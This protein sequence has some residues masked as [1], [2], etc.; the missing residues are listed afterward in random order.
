MRSFICF[1]VMGAVWVATAKSF[2][3]SQASS[4]AECKRL[5]SEAQTQIE[6]IES[7]IEKNTMSLQQIRIDL[8]SLR[9]LLQKE[10]E[11]SSSSKLL[12][13]PG[14]VVSPLEHSNKR[15]SPSEM[16]DRL[17]RTHQSVRTPDKPTQPSGI[18]LTS[19]EIDGMINQIEGELQKPALNMQSIRSILSRLRKN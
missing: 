3:G 6:R 14:I 13:E 10:A 18:P 4:A 19:I 9:K 11:C 16:L 8:D 12:A 17:S 2:A 7:A 15:P 1:L 5:T